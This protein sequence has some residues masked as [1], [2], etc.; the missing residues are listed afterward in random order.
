VLCSDSPLPLAAYPRSL[1]DALPILLRGGHEPGAAERVPEL[2]RRS[3][4]VRGLRGAAAGVGGPVAAQ[5]QR[6]VHSAGTAAGAGPHRRG[7]TRPLIPFTAGL[8][9]R[10]FPHNDKKELDT[11]F[12]RRVQFLLQAGLAAVVK[13]DSPPCCE[14]TRII[15]LSMDSGYRLKTLGNRHSEVGAQKK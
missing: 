13:N 4:A 11:P 5:A 10:A 14:T 12:C 9:T 8:S 7:R 15:S 1:H 2:R 3:H 6:P